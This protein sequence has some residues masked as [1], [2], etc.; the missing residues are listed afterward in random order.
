M[1]TIA[2]NLIELSGGIRA[3]AINLMLNLNIDSTAAYDEEEQEFGFTF[4]DGSM[5]YTWG[6]EVAA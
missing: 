2:Q 5:I 1:K 6:D 3:K 4:I